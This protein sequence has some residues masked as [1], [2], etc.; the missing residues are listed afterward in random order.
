MKKIFL[1]LSMVCGVVMSH[2]ESS[3]SVTVYN[4]NLALV[5]ESRT[6]ELKKG[7]QEYR[8]V[9]VA[10]QLDPTS[11]HFRSIADPQALQILE[12]NFEYD[13]VGTDRLLE[14]YIDQPI[15]VNVKE[16]EAFSGTL[17]SAQGGDVVLQ[18]QDGSVK[19]LKAGALIKIEFPALPQGLITR[20][21]LVWLLDSKDAGK[22]NSEIS[23]LTGGMDWHAEYVAV[24]NPA[25]TELEISGWVSIQNNS[26]ASYQDAKI[27][28]VAGD[29]HQAVPE[30]PRYSTMKALAMAPTDAQF[31]EKAFFEYHLYTLQRAATL[32]DKQLKQISLFPPA[33]V[34]VQKIY[35][36]NGA[37]DEKKVR[38]NL[39]FKNDKASGLGMAL[40][41]GKIR[42][43]K[44]D[45]D[46]SQEY[47]GED[48]IDHTPRDEK[49]T[50][51]LGNAFDIVGERTVQDVKEISKHV[52]Q[53]VIVISL[54]N[55]KDIDVK[56]HVIENFWGD[57]EFVGPTPPIIKRDANKV[58]FEVAVPANNETQFVYTVMYKQ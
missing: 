15:V 17:L 4:N 13:L 32:L 51:Y 36:Y 30:R 41:K 12:Q 31:E 44:K 52:R 5:R 18:A 20:P 45:T 10:S 11:V 56:V 54:R 46:G 1:V 29:V 9:D 50:V 7:V 40:P 57:W 24:T 35:S 3:V 28:L 16:G 47:I 25:D 55:H 37:Q 48:F 22:Q 6:L 49:V 8:Y 2:A 42:V 26:G 27:K 38:V 19:I 23:Y 33:P 58:E 53:E 39:E 21:T 14:K 34:K 43:Y